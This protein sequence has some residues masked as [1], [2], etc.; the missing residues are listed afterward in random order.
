VYHVF[1]DPEVLAEVRT[2]MI[3][4]LTTTEKNGIKH[5]EVDISQIRELPILKSI[6]HEALR[7]YASGTGTRVVVE[8]IILD[9]KYLLKK[10]TFVFMPNRSF[11]F[12]HSV[13]GEAVDEFDAHRFMKTK[14]YRGAFRAFGGGANLCPGRLF[15]MNSILAMC[16]MLAI[17]YDIKPVGRFWM[18]PGT[19]DSNMTLNV[20]PPKEKVEVEIVP[21]RGW[22]G[23]EW[24]FKV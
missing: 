21:R 24:S 3:P 10:D 8:D 22:T 5:H 14:G 9:N 17:R 12:N 16:A 7:H 13:W 11:H 4:L 6:L 2:A 15:A 1:A 19:D 20:H 18:H 23:A